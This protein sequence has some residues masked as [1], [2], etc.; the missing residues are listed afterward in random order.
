MIDYDSD[1][2]KRHFFYDGKTFTDYSPSA[3]FYGTVPAPA[4]NS[5]TLADNL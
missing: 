1:M 4:T 3:G 2:K 5:E